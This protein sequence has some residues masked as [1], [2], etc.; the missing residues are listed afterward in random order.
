MAY[1]TITHTTTIG[2]AAGDSLADL[3]ALRDEMAEWRDGMEG[4]GLE[5]TEKF[6]TVSEVA[7]GLDAAYEYAQSALEDEVLQGSIEELPITLNTQVNKDKRRGNSRAVR[8]ANVASIFDS[9]IDRLNEMANDSEDA[10]S[11]LEGELDMLSGDPDADDHDIEE[12]ENEIADLQRDVEGWQD[13][14][15]QLTDAMSDVECLDFPGMF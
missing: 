1:K 11:A 5:N 7:D 4:T 14:V 3:E 13:V 15:Q 8:A 12:L 9:I 2:T 6:Q 10:A